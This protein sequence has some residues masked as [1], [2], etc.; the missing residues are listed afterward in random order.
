MNLNRKIASVVAAGSLLL[1]AVTPIY[2]ATTFTISGN[3]SDSENKVE[4]S[5]TN[6]TGVTQ[7]NTAVITNNVSA[8]GATGGNE[9]SD[10]TN[11]DVTVKTGD[12][13]VGVTV[14]NTANSNTASVACCA[15]SDTLIKIL[16]NGSDSENKVEL[17]QAN[18]VSV[19]QNNSAIVE[20]KVDANAKTG[21]NEAEDNTGG[22]VLVKTGDAAAG[23]LV[24]NLLNSNEAAVSGCCGGDTKAVIAGNGTDSE[25]ELELGLKSVDYIDQGNSA[26]VSNDVDA[27]AK[28]G[29]NEAEDNTGGSVTVK[30]GDADVSASVSTTANANKA[31]IGSGLLGSA[32]SVMLSIL[33]N[34]ADTENEIELGLSRTRTIEQGNLAIVGNDVDADAKTGKNEAEDNTGGNVTIET[35]DAEAVL[36]LSNKLNFNWAEMDC[37]ALGVVGELS[38]N[39]VDSENEIEAALT[40]LKVATQG[41]EALL[42]NDVNA[43]P[44]TGYNE[45]EDNTGANGGFSDPKIETGDAYALVTVANTGNSNS[46]GSVAPIDWPDYDFSFYVS[47]AQLVAYFAAHS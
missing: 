13:T 5:S 2:A 44:K 46:F 16:G 36:A 1:Q 20:N 39:G 45:A 9:A 3:G 19:I 6:T 32:G 38:G 18:I 14:K 26:I 10:N 27:D 31:A 24:K 22:S 43:D 41:N 4:Y 47:W 34:G 12:A 7:N 37:C 8:N 30:T 33:N 21:A 17:G 15:G 28:T 23:T 40:D 11:G 35:G 29:A 42:G 25:N